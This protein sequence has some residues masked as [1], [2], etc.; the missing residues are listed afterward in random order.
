MLLFYESLNS[1]VRL[2][3]NAILLGKLKIIDSMQTPEK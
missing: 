1:I 3:L 2:K